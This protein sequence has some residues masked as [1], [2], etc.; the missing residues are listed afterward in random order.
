MKEERVY[1]EIAYIPQRDDVEKIRRE[2]MKLFD[3]SIETRED[4]WIEK[5][6]GHIRV[7]AVKLR[8]WQLEN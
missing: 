2:I 6:F 4:L 1:V 7:Y 8:D 3:P 5:G